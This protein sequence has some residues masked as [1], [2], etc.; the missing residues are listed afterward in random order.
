ME[1]NKNQLFDVVVIGAGPAG[2]NAAL[3]SIRKGNKVIV[4]GMQ[5]G[6]QTMNTSEVENY[7]GVKRIDGP[8]L[9]NLFKEH[10][11]ELGVPIMEYVML[12]KFETIDNIHHVHLSDGTVLKSKT[13]IVTIG[14]QSRKLQVP[15]EEE[16]AGMGVAYCAICDAPFYKGKD[17]IIAG[18][19][20]AATEAAL[21]L[22]KTSSHVTIVHRSQFRADEIILKELEK[23]ENV[24]IHLNSPI[25]EI[26]GDE[27]V[28]GVR[29]LDKETGKEFEVKA[30]GVFIEIGH[31]PNTQAFE[32]IL[33]L[34]AH[35]E[36]IVNEKCATNIPGVF[37]AGDIT[38]VPYKQIVIAV[39][40][41][42]TAALGA[43]EY[44]NSFKQ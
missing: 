26:L 23:K 9:A 2:L 25:Q 4:V 11:E 42:A 24:T 6:G 41:G 8:G 36:I 38:N 30:E 19:G 15:G 5:I 20:N 44:I 3:Y 17:V 37:A 21:D 31:I 1:V 33:E 32:G 39:A 34:N 29:A 43:N 28:T 22:S 16:F 10:V 14:S 12:E 13:I 7:L 40:Q 35:K 27:V 18:G